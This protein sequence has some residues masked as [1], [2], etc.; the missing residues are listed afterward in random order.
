M[1]EPYRI[2]F[3][4]GWHWV[5]PTRSEQHAADWSAFIAPVAKG[6]RVVFMD[7][8]LDLCRTREEARTRIREYKR[9]PALAVAAAILS[10]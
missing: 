9:N 5:R 4:D 3:M 7:E 2:P 1:D 6:W 8:P 10:L